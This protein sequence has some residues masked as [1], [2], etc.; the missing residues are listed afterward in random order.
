[1]DYIN[2]LEQRG[3]VLDRLIGR[4]VMPLDQVDWLQLKTIQAEAA[5]QDISINTLATEMAQDPDAL[6]K[7][8]T[9]FEAA[10]QQMATRRT[11]PIQTVSVEK[12]AEDVANS[13][14]QPSG[15][16]LFVAKRGEVYSAFL[17]LRNI[18]EDLGYGCVGIPLVDP[19]ADFAPIATALHGRC[20][21]WARDH[22]LQSVYSFIDQRDDDIMAACQAIGYQRKLVMSIL[23]MSL[24]D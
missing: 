1:M 4:W 2:F 19:E 3:F 8:A 22:G 11:T 18:E 7:L 21:A 23:E 15:S 9:L 6:H 10:Q 20:L 16:A 13:S 5:A 17:G 14:I 12:L 24:K